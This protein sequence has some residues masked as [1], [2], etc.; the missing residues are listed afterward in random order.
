MNPLY[1][2][3]YIETNIICIAISSFILFGCYT[4]ARRDGVDES[5]IR[6][7]AW[8][9]IAFC[10]S[11]ILA[12]YFRGVEGL[13]VKYLLYI[14]NIFYVSVP[15][16]FAFLFAEYSHYKLTG[17][18]LIKT[19][20]G[21]ILLIPLLI[22]FAL[23]ISTPLTHF[24]FV[25]DD[26]NLYQRGIGAFVI[27]FVAWGY[28]LAT[29]IRLVFRIIKSGSYIEKQ[30]LLPLVFFALWP[31]IANILQIKFYGIT[32]SQVGFTLSIL[33]VYITRLRNQILNDELT[34][35]KNSRDFNIYI[36]NMIRTGVE[37]E[38]Y[39]LIIDVNHF[40]KINDKYGHTEGDQVLKKIGQII[41]DTCMEIDHN[42]FVCRYG[43]DEFLVTSKN[44]NVM[45]VEQLKNSIRENIQQA[46]LTQTKD[47]DFSVSIGS[48][49]G[50]IYNNDDFLEV[51]EKAFTDMYVDKRQTTKKN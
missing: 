49:C 45:E 34:N 4:K 5:A 21:K 6:S 26:K 48:S 14:A 24:G 18:E 7:F 37:H 42:I 50:I 15:L 47:Y 16:F 36:N 43:G 1:Y 17:S 29:T 39:I 51:M 31:L 9:N 22:T 38:L 20:K 32:V 13:A 10:I 12:A 19:M 28:Y 44:N 33:L 11:D 3:Y 35:L 40:K 8:V 25:I 30:T 2:I 23:M 46:N 41:R 27:P